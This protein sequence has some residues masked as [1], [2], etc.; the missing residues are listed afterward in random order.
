[1]ADTTSL[2]LPE[3]LKERVGKVAQ[4]VA[5]TP[6]AYMVQAIAEKVDRDEKR[7]QFLADGD[8][9]LEEFKRTGIA[10]TH[11]DVKRYLL[12]KVAGKNPRKP[13]PIR[14]PKSRR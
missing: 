11:E 9:A 5:Q 14:I 7:Q 4:G 13:K 2:K 1:M 3:D 8:R 12:D 10:Y 6:H